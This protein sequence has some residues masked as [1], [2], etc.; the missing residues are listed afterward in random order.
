MKPY[1]QEDGQTIYLGDCREILPALGR[2]DL[3]LTDPPYELT[4]AGGGIVNRRKY[5]H[6]IKNFTD[7]G[8]DLDILDACENWICFCAKKQ[9]PELLAKAATMPRWMLI[10]WNKPNPTPLCNGN[11][12]P[13]TE[14][15]LHGFQA[16]R[17]FGTYKDKS[18]FIVHP[19][20]QGNFHPNEKP[21]VILT[22]M[23]S[24][25]CQINDTVI[26][27][28]C[29]SGSTLVAAQLEGRQAIG[30]EISERYCEIA[31]NRLRQKVLF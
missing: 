26:D 12:L 22:K 5:M 13:D 4:A 30:I 15:I 17:C 23:L 24:V 28:F 8:F 20:Q 7:G 10:T 31:A 16:N 11:Y 2:F 25:G 18:R 14:Y 1:Y 21:L 27:P 3:L 19:A 6:D 29:G 9:L